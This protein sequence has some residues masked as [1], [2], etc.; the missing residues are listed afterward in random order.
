LEV[1]TER[2]VAAGRSGGEVVADHSIKQVVRDKS[3]FSHGQLVRIVGQPERMDGEIFVLA[4]LDREEAGAALQRDYAQP[5]AAFQSAAGRAVRAHGEGQ[6]ASFS[7]A[8]REALAVAPVLLPLLAEYRAITG[9]DGPEAAGV[10]EQLRL[11]NEQAGRLRTETQLLL[12]VA[13]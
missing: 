12:H 13:D 5:L 3:S 10:G 9:R 1:E 6:R 4:C 8:Y 2:I 11:I 7:A